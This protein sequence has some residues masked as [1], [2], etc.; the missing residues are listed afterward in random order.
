MDIDLL[1]RECKFRTS[2]SSGSGGQH[3]NKVST[4]VELL[5]N[6]EQSVFLSESQKVKLQKKLQNRVNSE[7]YISIVCQ[8]S[9]SQL[10]NKKI[11][12]KKFELLLLDALKKEKKRKPVKPLT[13]NKNKRLDY[14]RRNSEKKAMRKKINL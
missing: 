3:V 9:R 11:A 6:I 14:K 10:K 5:F 2:R 4:K 12:I 8:E 1:I 13:A 7:G